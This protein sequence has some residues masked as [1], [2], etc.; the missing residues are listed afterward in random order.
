MFSDISVFVRARAT[1]PEREAS[2]RD[3]P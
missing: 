2:G 1:E 3:S